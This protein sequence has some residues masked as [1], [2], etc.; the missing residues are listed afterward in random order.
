MS[1]KILFIRPPRNIWPFVAVPLPISESLQPLGLASVAA[2]VKRRFPNYTVKI[3][4]CMPLQIGWN[5]L[6]QIIQKER[7]DIVGAG[8]NFVYFHESGKLFDL[9]KELNPGTI[10]L[11]GGHFFSWM[12]QYGLKK[13][14]VDYIV[15]FEGEETICHLLEYLE[16]GADPE[17]VSGIAFKRNE[18]VITTSLRP[19]IDDL[20][21]LPIPAFDMLPM[22]SYDSRKTKW[23][24]VV[25][26]EHS[27][28]CVDQ[29]SFCALWTFWGKQSD[30][31]VENNDL[32]VTPC[33]RTKSVGRVIDEIDLV[34]KK[35]NRRNIYWVDPTFNCD[36][37]WNDA[38]CEALIKK[39]YKDL[40]WWAFMRADFLVRDERLG[41]LEKM[42]RSGLIHSFI[43]VER[44][45]CKDLQLIKKS[46]YGDDIAREAF[47]ILRHKYPQVMRQ[48]SFVTCL[49]HDN[50]A[51]MRQLA[52]YA[53][54][55]DLDY[56]L[57]VPVMPF[58]GTYLYRDL[59]QSESVHKDFFINADWEGA[60]VIPDAGV[61]KEKF[62]DF[63]IKIYSMY[64][65]SNPWWLLKRLFSGDKGKRWILPAT[66]L[67]TFQFLFLSRLKKVF[68]NNAV[69]MR[70]CAD[71]YRPKWYNN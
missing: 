52:R 16:S 45:T 15:R 17:K 7:P 27:R 23:P 64:L 51:S 9:V 29:C 57:F 44:D 62:E 24:G 40:K 65:F 4:D 21:Q 26:M 8:D 53:Q 13:F 68:K 70:C 2:A 61:R 10:N 49:P 6:R 50:K 55:V 5:K 36:P 67:L 60:A 31:L 20:D 58:P 28:G 32:A 35:Y 25:T 43:G 30:T 33:Y 71:L 59:V 54:T 42:V 69:L 39:N 38:F 48:G 22:E 11:A 34:Y 47:G 3:I 46:G 56:A 14:P 37:E 12:V 66:I 41:I 63:R 1:K 18:K 19:L